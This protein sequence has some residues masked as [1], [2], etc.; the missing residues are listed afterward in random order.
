MLSRFLAFIV[1]CGLIGGCSGKPTTGESSPERAFAAFRERLLAGDHDSAY[2]LFSEDT[3]QRYSGYEFWGLLTKTKA[4]KLITHQLATWEL[5][6]V[7]L[8]PDGKSAWLT[9]RHPV[10]PEFTNRYE[11][12]AVEGAT[13]EAP[14]WKIRF[15]LADVLGSPR[16]EEDFLFGQRNEE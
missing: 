6:S 5:A 3:Q 7:E 16:E 2:E 8:S 14:R 15:F 1:L 11:L 12:I 4:G 9:L 13:G 10:K